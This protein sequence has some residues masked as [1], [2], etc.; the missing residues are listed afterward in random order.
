MRPAGTWEHQRREIIRRPPTALETI[1]RIFM[2]GIPSI[3]ATFGMLWTVRR[4]KSC[5]HTEPPV[6]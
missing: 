6:G 3:A 2:W 5:H 4:L 1:E